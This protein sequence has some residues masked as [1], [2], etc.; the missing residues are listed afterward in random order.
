MTGVVPLNPRVKFTDS[1]GA[2]IAGG[3]VTVYLAGTTALAN[4]YQDKALTTLN[5]NPITLDADGECVMWV[6]SQYFY[7]FLV[8]DSNGATVSGYPVDN[9]PG[10]AD[11]TTAAAA[12]KDWATKTDASVDGTGFSAKE[13]AQGSQ[14]STGGSAKNWSQQTGADVTGGATHDRSAKSW[15]Q[16]DLSS[17]GANLGGSAK[18]WAQN[19]SSPDG[20]GKSAKAYSQDASTSASSAASYAAA[21]ATGAKFYS[22][23][24]LGN[25][26]VADGATFGVVAG[27]S[28]GLT[29]P[30]IYQRVSSGV[31]TALYSVLP[32]SEY[33]GQFP[34]LSG[35]APVYGVTD[36][37][38]NASSATDTAGT[39]T[40]G[41]VVALQDNGLDM[42]FRSRPASLGN[43]DAEL[44]VFIF[45]GQSNMLGR[46]PGVT[47]A[48]EYDNIAFGYQSNSPGSYSAATVLNST[49]AVGNAGGFSE[50]LM[51][52]TLGYIKLL[53]QQENGLGV[54]D[55]AFQLLGADNSQGST[56][57]SVHQKG[58]SYYSNATS[59]A[60]SAMTIAATQNRSVCHGGVFWN[61]G[62]ADGATALA[63]YQSSMQTLATNYN[64][65]LKVIT[66]QT[67]DITFITGQTASNSSRNVALA[68]L[69]ASLASSL[70][71]VACPMGQFL[72]ES[73]GIHV[74]ALHD[75]WMAAYYGLAW[76]RLWVDL[77]SWKPT[78]PISVVTSGKVSYV[79]FDCMVQPLVLDT[80]MSWLPQQTNYGFSLLSGNSISSVSVVRPN[81][82]KIVGAGNLSGETLQYGFNTVVGRSDAFTGACGNLRDSQGNCVP[83]MDGHPLHNWCLTS[84]IAL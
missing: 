45:D 9:V 77:V 66:G 7:K 38:G 8:T 29:R 4:T 18:D 72:Y 70:I 43:F 79:T 5:T 10:G 19:P 32:A 25:A 52:G 54:S 6:S 60:T 3:S 35:V 15:A 22:T 39:V 1:S 37:R 24:A 73:D 81:V 44:M 59:Q 68:Q 27:G 36:D 80:S 16:D 55:I 82:V 46:N 30:S 63:T 50:S 20:S 49:A 17:T 56:A 33:D 61:Q 83:L 74:I 65:D 71:K 21:A 42:R 40:F 53:L 28:D 62:E 57:I 31:S 58:S 34:V 84:Q 78:R 23:I 47:Y 14:A 76:K 26:G 2:P 64:T 67:K 41:N 13:F 48:Q 75:R 69:A 51:L 12:A 11:V